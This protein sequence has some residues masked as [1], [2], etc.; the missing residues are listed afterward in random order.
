MGTDL[1]DPIRERKIDFRPWLFGVNSYG[2]VLNDPGLKEAMEETNRGKEIKEA[3]LH[4]SR[5][6]LYVGFTRAR[7]KLILAH[8]ANKYTWLKEL[9]EIDTFLDPN[10]DEGSSL[11]QHGITV[12]YRLRRFT[13]GLE[14][15]A[16]SREAIFTKRQAWPTPIQKFNPICTKR[17]HSPSQADGVEE[18]RLNLCRLPGEK[19]FPKNEW[20]DRSSENR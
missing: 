12:E 4:E 17:F 10:D 8:S 18:V 11:R 5:R 7:D 14:D 13:V 2:G 19:C 20:G 6:L 15:E 1:E 16:L 3:E 9:P